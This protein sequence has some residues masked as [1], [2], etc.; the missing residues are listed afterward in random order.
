MN[1]KKA[2]IFTFSFIICSLG[3]QVFGQTFSNDKT[4]LFGE[5]KE[6][7]IYND[8]VQGKLYAEKLDAE[9]KTNMISNERIAL[10]QEFYT[11]LAKKKYRVYPFYSSYLDA[12]FASSYNARPD[13]EFKTWQKAALF[14]LRKKPQGTCSDFLENSFRLFDNNVIYES[15][16]TKWMV[17]GGYRLEYE[18]GKEPLV[19]FSGVTLIT[20]SRNDSALIHNTSGT[21]L[22]TENKW[23]GK[24]GIVYWERAGMPREWVSAQLGK[25]AIALKTPE[26]TADSVMFSH[27]RYFKEPIMGRMEEKVLNNVTPENASYPRF[28]GYDK[29]VKLDQLSED[30]SYLGGFQFNGN[31]FIGSGDPENPALIIF[32]RNN[33]PFIK[34]AALNYA[35]RENTISSEDAEVTIYINKNDTVDSIYQPGLNFKY[36]TDKRELSLLRLGSG[37]QKSL[38]LNSYHNIDMDAEALYWK[39]NE[40]KIELSSIKG[41]SEGRAGFLSSNYFRDGLYERLDGVGDISPLNLLKQ[42]YLKNGDRKT[43]T[44]KETAMF[45]RDDA[46][47]VRQFLMLMSIYG[48]I[49]YNINRDEYIVKDRFFHIVNAHSRLTDYDIIEF[50]SVIREKNATLSLMDYNLKMRGIG[51][52]LLSDSQQVVIY[53]HEQEITM[54]KDMDFS[55]DGTVAA[56]KFTFFGKTYFMDYDKFNMNMPS[57]DSIRMAV[58]RFEQDERGQYL[59]EKVKTAI[60]DLSGNLQI[61]APLNKSGVKPLASFPIFTSKKPSYTF[62]NNRSIAGGVYKKDEFYFQI[63]PFVIDSMDVFPTQNLLL[64]GTLVSAGIFPDIKDKLRVMPDYSLGIRA[65]TPG[66]GYPIYGGPAKYFQTVTMSHE[67]LRGKGRLEY[68]TAKT[69]SDDF[70]FYPD[71]MN[72][73]AK[74]F[75][76]DKTTGKNGTPDVNAD[77]VYVHWEPKNGKYDVRNLGSGFNMYDGKAKLDGRMTVTDNGIK[78]GGK[79]DLGKAELMAADYDL[80]TDNILTDSSNF[81][82]KEINTETG[83]EGVSFMAQNMKTDIDFKLRKGKF[84]ANNEN[85][86]VDFPI[87]KYR[88][89]SEKIDWNMDN[90]DIELRA[91]QENQKE[92]F[93]FV[94][95]KAGQDSLEFQSPYALFKAS[96]KVIYAEKVAYIDVADSRVFLGDGKVTLR[97]DAR[98]D[99]LFNTTLHMPKEKPFHVLKNGRVGIGGKFNIGGSGTYEYKDKTGRV[100]NIFM[101]SLMVDSLKQVKAKGNIKAADS[102]KFM[103]NVSYKGDFTLFSKNPEPFVKGYITLDHD[104]PLLSKRWM[105]TE[106]FI[107]EGDIMIPVPLEARDEQKNI[108]FNGFAFASDS[109]GIYP[110][111]I[112]GKKNYADIE[113]VSASGFLAYDVKTGEYRVGSKE[114][115]ANPDAEGNV[116]VFKPSDC[117]AYGEGKLEL[118]GKLGQ[119]STVSAGRINYLPADTTTELDVVF[120]INFYLDNSIWDLIFAKIKEYQSGSA[121]LS[122]D[123]TLKDLAELIP[124]KKDREKFIAKGAGIDKLPDE[125]ATTFMF[126]NVHLYWNKKKRSLYHSGNVG[127]ISWNGKLYNRSAMLKME[128]N[129]KRGG[130]AVTMYIEFDSNNWYYFNY[131]NNIM[132]FY[133]SYN[134]E[135]NN[136]VVELDASKRTVEGKNGV[137]TYQFTLGTKRRVELFLESFND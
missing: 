29:R 87:N 105:E 7:L 137:P 36:L 96:D 136:K 98:M 113:V 52:V 78:G 39:T 99:S 43:F 14:V 111:L 24:G 92:G 41:S 4:K 60:H 33:E 94:S 76:V 117:S 127:I 17:Y 90:N 11:E 116:M 27:T 123:V 81:K 38:Y 75:T 49:S 115:L 13:A 122:E 83:A 5:L 108:M 135:I 21:W 84:E 86:Y 58:K 61:D 68:L 97:D 129:R 50:N 112:S 77:S 18:E 47:Q 59:D 126:S 100:Q 70:R 128:I 54:Y 93:R 20:Y 31:K 37:L 23:V 28:Q 130:D 67:G 19:Q 6:I 45:L 34:I 95:T 26:Y 104:C 124:N 46:S 48:L 40:D 56:G 65:Q 63:E 22:M 118:G 79:I 3:T 8:K 10:M 57:V 125:L 80:K 42:F 73:L 106:G 12:V 109:S 85:A 1:S 101:N 103:P 114:R 15:N 121:G 25:Y 2:F 72:A 16:S 91:K 69:E 119:V 107:G 120:G 102:L 88:A 89:F 110:V 51:S 82:L 134:T 30:V 66:T 44:G 131:R 133:S 132:Q 62:Y 35:F 9:L 55:F 64:D 74:R 32:N 53:P 71:S